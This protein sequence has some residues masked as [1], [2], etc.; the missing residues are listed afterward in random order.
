MSILSFQYLVEPY[1]LDVGMY[2]LS[3]LSLAGP[4]SLSTT[5]SDLHFPYLAGHTLGVLAI[6]GLELKY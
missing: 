1:P 2:A 5:L 6:S 3:F 4:R